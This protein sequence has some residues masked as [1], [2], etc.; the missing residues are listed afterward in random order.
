MS[1]EFIIKF[2]PFDKVECYFDIVAV[3][4]N[5][6]AGLGSNVERNFVLSTKT[7]VSNWQRCYFISR[8][9]ALQIVT[10]TVMVNDCTK[11]SRPYI[12]NKTKVSDT[13]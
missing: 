10:V 8:K 6:V 13:L 9:K 7:S 2:H 11:I 5:N 4:G 3:F 1:N 12:R